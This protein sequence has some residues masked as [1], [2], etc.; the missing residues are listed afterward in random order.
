[1][2]HTIIRSSRVTA[3]WLA[4]VCLGST[5]LSARSDADARPGRYVV[6]PGTVFDTKTKLTWEQDVAPSPYTW[7]DAGAYCKSLTLR[8]LDWRL[9][10]LKELAT[11]VD[12]SRVNPAIDQTAFPD[13]PARPFWTSSLV[14]SF[15]DSG[16][17][18]DFYRGGDN[19]V[20]VTMTQFVRCVH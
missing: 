11:L 5:L 7:T 4:L 3:A 2:S 10:S 1:M 14:T 19:F 18:V 20:A 15:P 13:T 12:D 6:K 17:T 16:W 9:P 8:N